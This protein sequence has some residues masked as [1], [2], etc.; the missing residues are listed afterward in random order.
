MKAQ[1]KLE[2]KRALQGKEGID[3]KS[4]AFEQGDII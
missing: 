1:Q 3:L 4:I 2:E